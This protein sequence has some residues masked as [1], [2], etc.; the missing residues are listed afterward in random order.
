MGDGWW[1]ASD[2]KWYPQYQASPLAP[3]TPPRPTPSTREWIT[4]GA[5]ALAVVVL[6]IVADVTQKDDDEVRAPTGGRSQPELL[7]CP[8]DLDV[9][10]P[11]RVGIDPDYHPRRDWDGDGVSCE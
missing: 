5:V 4:G 10:G 9:A 2:G 6:I 8:D 7:T 11:Y 1:Q 3:P